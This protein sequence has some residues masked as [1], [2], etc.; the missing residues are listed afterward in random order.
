MGAER[1]A[2]IRRY[3]LLGE[4]E[5]NRLVEGQWADGQ[6]DRLPALAAARRLELLPE[7]VPCL[8]RLAILANVGNPATV[9]HSCWRSRQPRRLRHSA[10]RSCRQWLTGFVTGTAAALPSLSV[11]LSALVQVRAGSARPLNR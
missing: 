4:S 2:S 7:I 10:I 6:Y 3:R 9:P 5:R 11:S 1:A 8:G